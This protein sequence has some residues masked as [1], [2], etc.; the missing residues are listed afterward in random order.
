MMTNKDVL[1]FSKGVTGGEGDIYNRF[2]ETLA[3][4]ENNE[5]F[6]AEIA[7]W[8]KRT[9]WLDGCV[10]LTS[11][12]LIPWKNLFSDV[13]QYIIVGMVLSLG[14]ISLLVTIKGILFTL[15][16]GGISVIRRIFVKEA[17]R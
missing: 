16:S 15:E 13:L 5:K 10:I 6:A 4:F 3:S 14:I 2:K 9:L 7:K 12:F 1:S 17:K 11:L 8:F